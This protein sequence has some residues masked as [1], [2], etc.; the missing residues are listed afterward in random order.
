MAC[1]YFAKFAGTG[2]YV[3]LNGNCVF[4]SFVFAPNLTGMVTLDLRLKWV[5]FHNIAPVR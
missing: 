1:F 2:K 4:F 3:A 5:S